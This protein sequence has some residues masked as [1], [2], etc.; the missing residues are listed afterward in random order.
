M[1]MMKKMMIL[2]VMATVT[3]SRLRWVTSS[4]SNC[5]KPISS[6]RNLAISEVTAR[7]K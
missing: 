3:C 4:N 2:A 1:T 6:S 5:Y 7:C